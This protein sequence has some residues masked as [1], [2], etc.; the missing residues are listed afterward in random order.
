MKITYFIEIFSSWCYWAEPAWA[1]LKSRYAGRVDFQW[2][3]A[4]M[5]PGDF[6]A[7]REQCD[8]FYQR[9]GTITHSPFMLNS[10]WFDPALK[11]QYAAPNY[12]AEAGRDFGFN[13]DRL[14]LA[15]MHAAMREGRK[16]GHMSEAVSVAA[17]A[18]GIDAEKLRAR[19]ESTEVQKRVHDSTAEFHSLKINQRPA[20]LL[21]DPIGDRAVFSGLVGAVPLAATLDAMLSDSAAY[22]SYAVHFGPPPPK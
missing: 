11:A 15:L 10:G 7:S 19:A 4:L 20:F 13:D 17:A 5:N 6:P 3:I 1:E 2:K 12:V 18:L 21:E 16:I 9:S 14:R 8:W 22:A